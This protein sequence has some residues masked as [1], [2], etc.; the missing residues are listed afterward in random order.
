LFLPTR[1]K[2][3][4]YLDCVNKI[5]ARS[6]LLLIPLILISAGAVGQQ[7]LDKALMIDTLD[8]K[9][10]LSRFLIEMHGFIPVPFVIT[11]PALGGFGGGLAAV[12]LRQ[13]PLVIDTI[14]GKAK[15]NFTR[16]DIT[17]FAG[18]YTL[19]D[20]YLLGAFHSGTWIKARSKYRLAGG[21]GDI[22][23]SFYNTIAGEEREYTFNFR[24]IPLSGRLEKQFP[25]TGWSAGIRYLFLKSTLSAVGQ[26]MPEFVSNLEIESL[27][28]MPALGIVYDT[29]DNMFS[30]NRGYLIDASLSWSDPVFGSDYSYENLGTYALAYL[31][32]APKLIGGFRY[33][34]QQVFG[35]PPFYLKPF[36]NLRGIPA[37]RYQGNIVSVVETE[38]RWDI[39]PRWSAVAFVGSGRAHDEW[40]DFNN[41]PW[42]SSGGAGFRYLA[43]RQFKLR[44]GLDV[45]RSP[46]QW[47][48]YIV[49]GSAWLR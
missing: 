24:T 45:A 49:F 20:S 1:L 15:V 13:R 22:N 34:F 19:N 7:K 33:D 2:S 48:Y 42:H 16:P 9:M 21:F 30:P 43:A 36:I 14:R 18:M 12:F 23:L 8:G 3:L 44:V 35:S 32:F 31:S 6:V 4:S 39:V 37:A 28:S 17:G 29:R 40:S 10:D 38:F 26:D 5:V 27:V 46:G 25:G 47:A 11:E 41:A